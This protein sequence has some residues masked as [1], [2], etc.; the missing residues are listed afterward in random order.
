MI[1]LE[2]EGTDLVSKVEHNAISCIYIHFIYIILHITNHVFHE[3][4]A[5]AI[6]ESLML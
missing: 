3:K 6:A 1:T 2:A 5:P 4:N